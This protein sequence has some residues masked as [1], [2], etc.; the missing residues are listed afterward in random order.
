MRL[1][2]MQHQLSPL[3][4]GRQHDP[5]ISELTSDSQNAKVQP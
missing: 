4:A 3:S 5:M 1:T 2:E